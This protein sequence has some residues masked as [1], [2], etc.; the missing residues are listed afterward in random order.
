MREIIKKLNGD[1]DFYK[2]LQKKYPLIKYVFDPVI[3]LL[4]KKKRDVF[5]NK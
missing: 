2:G 4:E 3:E 1:I 5:S